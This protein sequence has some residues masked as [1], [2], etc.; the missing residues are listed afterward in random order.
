MDLQTLATAWH[1]GDAGKSTGR[2]GRPRIPINGSKP[3]WVT[4]SRQWSSVELL[5]RIASTNFIC[6]QVPKT[7]QTEIFRVND[8]TKQKQW[9]QGTS[10]LNLFFM[11]NIH[12]VSIKIIKHSI[13]KGPVNFIL[14]LLA[15][16]K[17]NNFSLSVLFYPH[18]K[19]FCEKPSSLKSKQ[20]L[21]VYITLEWKHP[22]SS[23]SCSDDLCDSP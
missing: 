4:N 12:K 3:F 9:L 19:S 8:E 13:F 1:A 23:W 11:Q 17:S 7:L 5:L 14:N 10:L 6:N 21:L 20:A 15:G 16:S 2:F 18:D 22:S